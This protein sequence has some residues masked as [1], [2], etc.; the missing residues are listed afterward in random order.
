MTPPAAAPIRLELVLHVSRFRRTVQSARITIRR[1]SPPVI[2]LTSQREMTICFVAT[3]TGG[4]PGLR[5]LI[6]ATRKRSTTSSLLSAG[7][8]LS[9]RVPLQANSGFTS[10]VGLQGRYRRGTY[11]WCVPRCGGEYESPS[12]LGLAG[13]QWHA[14]SGSSTR[15]RD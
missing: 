6:S 13:D 3:D 2:C 7:R 5:S 11:L 1:A 8:T 9:A 4:A 14:R 15:R 10:R 12:K